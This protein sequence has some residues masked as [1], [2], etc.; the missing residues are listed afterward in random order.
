MRREVHDIQFD[1]ARLTP[2][3]LNGSIATIVRE[4]YMPSLQKMLSEIRDLDISELDE[5]SGAGPVSGKLVKTVTSYTDAN[6][7]VHTVTVLDE[8]A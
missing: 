3:P 8:Q 7:T 6:G 2:M 5:V 1:N 4:I